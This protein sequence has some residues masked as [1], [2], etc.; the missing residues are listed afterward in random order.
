[1]SHVERYREI[2][3]KGSR[4]MHIWNIG[5]S[6]LL[7]RAAVCG[8]CRVYR[9]SSADTFILLNVSGSGYPTDRCVYGYMRSDAEKVPQHKNGRSYA[10]TAELFYEYAAD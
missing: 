10:C 9:S 1:M 5:S 6:F 3:Q 4:A 7:Y 8:V 2:F